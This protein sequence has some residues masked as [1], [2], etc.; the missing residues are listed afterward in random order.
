MTCQ[1]HIA[2]LIDLAASGAKPGSELH[3]HLQACPSCR[4]ALLRERDLF[5]S[6]DSSLRASANA[7]IPAAFVQRVRVAVNQQSAVPRTSLFRPRLVFAVAAAAI[8]LFFVAH[9][10]HRASFESQENPI[11]QRHQ[12]PSNALQPKPP[13]PASDST[14]PR[15][16]AGIV[17]TRQTKIPNDNRQQQAQSAHRDPEILVSG[18]QE[19]L[20]ARYSEQLRRRNSLPVLPPAPAPPSGADSEVAQTPALQVLPIQ[21]AQLDVKPLEERQE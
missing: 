3:A 8:I 13:A 10:T 19:I 6:I 21:I 9:F 15:V 17:A 18:D 2:A 1:R 16:T 12:S 14:S 4:A 7:E 11:A 20:M 5:T